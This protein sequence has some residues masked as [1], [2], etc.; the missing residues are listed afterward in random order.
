M[1]END[2]YDRKKWA[3]VCIIAGLYEE[4]KTS[5]IEKMEAKTNRKAFHRNNLRK[6]A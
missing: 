3:N 1:K 6:L 4:T 5:G 2:N